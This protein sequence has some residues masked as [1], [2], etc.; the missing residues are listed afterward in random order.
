V[1]SEKDQLTTKYAGQAKGVWAHHP[2]SRSRVPSP[3]S[4]LAFP[5]HKISKSKAPKRLNEDYYTTFVWERKYCFEPGRWCPALPLFFGRVELLRDFW[6]F[7][8]PGIL[9]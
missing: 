9:L 6:L 2:R 4:A 5:P 1:A 3:F 8:T 7:W